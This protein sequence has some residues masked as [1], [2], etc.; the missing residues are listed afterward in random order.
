MKLTVYVTNS[1]IYILIQFS[2]L[3]KMLA[4]SAVLLLITTVNCH[5]FYI[6]T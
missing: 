2:I 6:V 5:R 1:K 4:G 3:V